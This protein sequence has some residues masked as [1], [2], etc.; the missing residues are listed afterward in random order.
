MSDEIETAKQLAT[1]PLSITSLV[2]AVGWLGNKVW[3]GHRQE[4]GG[5]KASIGK[6]GEWIAKLYEK[7]EA[8]QRRDEEMFLEVT[9]TMGA[10]H[11]EILKLLGEKEDR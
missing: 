9:R 5:M 10:N 11:A 4:I 6:Q 1:H 7:L 3:R 8:H 2:A